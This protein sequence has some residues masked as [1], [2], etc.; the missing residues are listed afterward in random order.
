VK[1]LW[2]GLPLFIMFILRA[3]T[4]LDWVTVSIG[5]IGIFLLFAAVPVFVAERGEDIGYGM[6]LTTL[7]IASLELEP[8][9]PTA[10]PSVGV[11]EP[12]DGAMVAATADRRDLARELFRQDYVL[13]H[14]DYLAALK[15]AAPLPASAALQALIAEMRTIAMVAGQ[16]SVEGPEDAKSLM[17]AAEA[18]RASR[19]ADELATVLQV[20]SDAHR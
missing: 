7:G 9:E 13:V 11:G 5:G 1:L 17:A 15:S 6:T 12:M 20:V 16:C 2:V 18:E 10:F 4:S 8:G 14:K 19:W 3:M